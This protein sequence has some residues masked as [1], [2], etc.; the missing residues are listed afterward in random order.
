[1]LAVARMRNADWQSLTATGITTDRQRNTERMSTTEMRGGIGSGKRKPWVESRRSP[2]GED[3][4]KIETDLAP[5]VNG[6][7]RVKGTKMR[8]AETNGTMTDEMT[9]A[10]HVTAKM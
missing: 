1:M 9:I 3:T 2:I 5:R 7:G 10:S 4:V 8:N 6:I